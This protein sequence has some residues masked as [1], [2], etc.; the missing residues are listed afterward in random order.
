MKTLT[1]IITL[2]LIPWY[3]NGQI[4]NSFKTSDGENLYYYKTGEGPVI[5]ILSG[6][7]GFEVSWLQPWADT[8]SKNFQCILFLT[9]KWFYCTQQLPNH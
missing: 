9:G 8:L 6:G 4:I 2:T 5:V 3:I 7:P 1:L